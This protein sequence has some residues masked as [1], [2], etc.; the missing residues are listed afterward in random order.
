MF[1]AEMRKHIKTKRLF[2][3]KSFPFN[4]MYQIKLDCWKRS[5]QKTIRCEVA[6]SRKVLEIIVQAMKLY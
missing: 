5:T 2:A 3:G 6:T 1:L 4:D